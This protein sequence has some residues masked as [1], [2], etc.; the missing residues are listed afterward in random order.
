MK[1][2]NAN[3]WGVA[4]PSAAR[5]VFGVVA[6]L[7]SFWLVSCSPGSDLAP[8]PDTAHG[9]YRLGVNE[10]VRVITFGQEQLT[11]QFRIND[12]GEIAVPL[13]GAIPANNQTTIELEHSIEQRLKQKGLMQDPNV[14]V[15]IVNYR[16]I[17]ILGEVAKPGQYA[18]QPGM[19][20]L[21]AVAIA[22]GFTYRAVTDYASIL[23]TSDGHAVEGRVP[24]NELVEPGD[25]IN[26]F[27]RHF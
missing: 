8:L 22:G 5:R 4:M 13:L 9:P 17:F 10:E 21:T 19:T 25:V 15:D 16:P 1:M 7:A 11:G 24:R 20:V 12:R 26:I 2:M 6:G 14:S 3:W 23:R 18:Y 27:E